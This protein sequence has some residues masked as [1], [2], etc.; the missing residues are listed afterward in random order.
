MGKCGL[1]RRQQEKGKREKR[2]KFLYLLYTGV[3]RVASL[4]IYNYPRTKINV[5]CVYES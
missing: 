1:P 5:F 3:R 4:L 2:F